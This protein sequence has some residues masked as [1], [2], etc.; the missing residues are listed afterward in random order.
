M[1]NEALNRMIQLLNFCFTR[2]R[3]THY[4]QTDVEQRKAFQWKCYVT[5]QVTMPS[6]KLVFVRLIYGAMEDPCNWST[7]LANFDGYDS[8]TQNDIPTMNINFLAILSS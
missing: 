5:M 6:H 1:K 8:K 3:L 2:D 4:K 7:S